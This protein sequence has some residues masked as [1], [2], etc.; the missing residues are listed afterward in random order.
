MKFLYIKTSPLLGRFLTYSNLIFILLL[1][2][3]SFFIA[4]LNPLA[5]K[6]PELRVSFMFSNNAPAF[7][8]IVY[9]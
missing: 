7:N 5:S 1:V 6:V 4:L 2:I 3:F 8:L 9:V